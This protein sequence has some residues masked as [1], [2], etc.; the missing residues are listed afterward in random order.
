MASFAAMWKGIH[1]AC[2]HIKNSGGGGGGG[3]G[4]GRGRGGIEYMI[5]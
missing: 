2:I 1:D 3:G 5:E 4:G